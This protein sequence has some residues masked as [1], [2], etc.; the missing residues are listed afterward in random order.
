MYFSFFKLIFQALV[1]MDPSD[2]DAD[3]KANLNHILYLADKLKYL[4]PM[5]T[6]REGEVSDM[7]DPGWL[8]DLRN[9]VEG[10]LYEQT[11][12]QTQDNTQQ[13]QQSQQGTYLDISFSGIFF[14][15]KKLDISF[16]SI[17]FGGKSG[18]IFSGKMDVQSYP[19]KQFDEYLLI[20]DIH[21]RFQGYFRSN[22]ACVK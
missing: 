12:N 9:M 20:I 15:K 13:Q 18:L 3:V 22:Y 11:Q 4:D 7:G 8:T 6:T 2:I 5:Y 21:P 1:K 14:S 10:K 16:S 17:I 19:M